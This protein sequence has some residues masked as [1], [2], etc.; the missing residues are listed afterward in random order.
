MAA[1]T[2]TQQRLQCSLCQIYFP[3]NLASL[4]FTL[5][6]ARLAHWPTF[7][8]FSCSSSSGCRGKIRIPAAQLCCCWGT[9]VVVGCKV[10]SPALLALCCAT[11]GRGKRVEV[12]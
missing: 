11:V 8:A 1:H 10:R 9:I 5:V 6:M 4:C 7:F 2:H 12:Y 3:C